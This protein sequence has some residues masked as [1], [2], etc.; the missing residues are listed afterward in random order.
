[1][2]P[3]YLR[4]AFFCERI[5]QDPDGVM[6]FVRVIDKIT[7]GPES[8][9]PDGVAE[10]DIDL[11][12][13]LVVVRDPE[14]Q[15]ETIQRNL[16]LRVSSPRQSSASWQYKTFD[17]SSDD[18]MHSFLVLLP[19]QVSIRETGIVLIQVSLDDDVLTHVPLAVE[20][21]DVTDPVLGRTPR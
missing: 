15:Q 8:V 14:N 1:M 4:S 7:L 16:S 18:D 6:T 17:F 10:L 9:R 11:A 2:H 12:V 3:V 13:G 20:F 19:V 21:G 5:T